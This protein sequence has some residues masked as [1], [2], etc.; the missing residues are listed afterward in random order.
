MVIHMPGIDNYTMI[1]AYLSISLLSSIEKVVAKVVAKLLS[2]E[3]ERS[4]LPSGGQFRSHKGRSAIHAVAIIVHRVHAAWRNGDITGMLPMD[5]NAA[6]PSQAIG[7]LV[8]VMKVRQMHCVLMGWTESCLLAR[9]V[10]IIIN[11]HTTKRHL[12][13]A[14]FLQ[15]SPVSPILFIVYTS[16]LMKWV[17]EYVS[18]GDRLSSVGDHCWTATGSCGHKVVMML[19]Q[20]TVTS[21]QWASGR[22]LQLHNAK[23]ETLLFRGRGSSRTHLR[24]KLTAII[25]FRNQIIR[26]N[27]QPTCL[28][29]VWLDTH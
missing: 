19:E 21:I 12:V 27:T 16:G 15:S 7:R 5:I 23:T 4:W 25:R 18:E 6:F 8:N 24:P 28:L 3:T 10:K 11:C 26:F 1:K 17:E 13:E 20:C 29:G 9:P 22:G 2:E 14:E